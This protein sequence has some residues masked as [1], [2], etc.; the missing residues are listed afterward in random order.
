MSVFFSFCCVIIYVYFFLV[1]RELIN[2]ERFI[3]RA[4]IIWEKGTERVAYFRGEKK[5]YGWVDI[6]S[7]FLP[8]DT[9]A[10]FLFAQLENLE[11]IQNKRSEIWNMYY[12]KLKP[13]ANNGKIKLP[14]IPLYSSNNNHLFY[15]IVKSENI[16]DEL[17]RYLKNADIHAVFHYLP[18]HLS[19]FYCKKYKGSHLANSVYFSKHL[20]RL[21]FYYELESNQI[22]Y[23]VDQI[24]NFFKS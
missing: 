18:L 10:A 17:L 3:K 7:S 12:R 13:L 19:Q 11:N 2:D 23:I 5:K 14:Y 4:E 15:I 21:P 9:T 1:K 24:I 8:A 22:Q 16:R 20:V 6:G